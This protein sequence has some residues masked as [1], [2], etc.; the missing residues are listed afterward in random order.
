M[1]IGWNFS[2]YNYGRRKVIKSMIEKL[3]EILL[4]DFDHYDAHITYILS[5]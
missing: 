3:V 5:P 2:P 4:Q 1:T